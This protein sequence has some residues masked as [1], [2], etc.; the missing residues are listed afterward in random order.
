MDKI[1]GDHDPQ[2][3][4]ESFKEITGI[5]KSHSFPQKKFNEWSKKKNKDDFKAYD[6]T[7]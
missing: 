3:E 1:K 4:Q 6:L 5:R 7:Q 2:P